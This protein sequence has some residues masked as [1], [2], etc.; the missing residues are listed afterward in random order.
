MNKLLLIITTSKLFWAKKGTTAVIK[1]RQVSE[2]SPNI[3][4]YNHLK[5]LCFGGMQ[6]KVVLF[7][8]AYNIASF[9]RIISAKTETDNTSICYLCKQVNFMF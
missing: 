3:Q 6:S 7:N 5:A 2:L 8:L 4:S 9:K 1:V